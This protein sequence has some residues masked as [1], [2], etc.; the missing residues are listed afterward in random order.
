MSDPLEITYPE[1]CLLGMTEYNCWG[2]GTMIPMTLKRCETCAR[3]AQNELEAQPLGPEGLA[4]N[5]QDDY[6]DLHRAIHRHAFYDH[7]CQ[8][9][10]CKAMHILNS[11]EFTRILHRAYQRGLS[12]GRAER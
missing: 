9:T 11:Q 4:D 12:D 6:R 1:A 8:S 5:E 10:G 7:D 2:C 3:I